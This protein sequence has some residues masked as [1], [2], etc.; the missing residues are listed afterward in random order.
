MPNTPNETRNG[1]PTSHGDFSSPVP[2]SSEIH[3]FSAV[4]PVFGDVPSTGP[5]TNAW[6]DSIVPAVTQPPADLGGRYRDFRPHRTGG[7]GRV[8]L[9]RDAVI[10]RD[11][12]LKELRPERAGVAALRARFLDE[13]RVTGQLEHPGIVPLYDLI[14]DPGRDG[15]PCY[16]MRFLAGRTFA[17]ATR[18]YH[19]TRAQGRATRL[20]WTALLDAFIAVCRAVAYAHARNVLHRD[21]KGENIVLGDFGEV[22]VVDWGLAKVLTGPEVAATPTPVVAP[23][24]EERGVT[25][26][27]AVF[28]T[29]AF[30]SPQLADG[31]SASIASDI[32][33]LGVI[34][35]ML[36]VGRLPYEGQTSADILRQIRASDPVPP[37]TLEPSVPLALDAICRKA[38]A[39]EPADRYRSADDLAADVRRWLADEPVEA[40]PDPWTVRLA[41]FARRNRT[42]VIATGAVLCS[43]VVAL[44]V[45]TGLIW[46]EQQRADQLRRRAEANF[47]VARGLALNMLDLA[48]TLPAA[49]QAEVVREGMT[50]MGLRTLEGFRSQRPDDHDLL[51]KLAKLYRYSANVHRNRNDLAVT[52][53]SY[54]EA[55]AILDV[56]AA[57]APTVEA[58]RDQLAET[59]RDH[60]QSLARLGRLTDASKELT[61]SVA[62]ASDLRAKNPTKTDYRRTLAISRLDLADVQLLLG[63]FRDTETSC[64]E[65]ETLLQGLSEPQPFDGLLQ[66][67]AIALRAEALREQAKNAEA[68]A[69]QSDAIT[70]LRTLHELAPDDINITHVLG[71]VLVERVQHLSATPEGRDRARANLDEAIRSWTDLIERTP[72]YPLYH[73][74]R[75]L[76]FV[77]RGRLRADTGESDA[78]RTD[79]RT[80]VEAFEKLVSQFP[81]VPGYMGHLGRTYAALGRL[82]PPAEAD[83]LFQRA[84]RLL[85]SACALAPDHA[86]DRRSLAELR[87]RGPPDPR[88]GPGGG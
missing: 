11:V 20:D 43:A 27:G 50:D 49:R 26:A 31:E 19:R 36:L 5:A 75:A 83:A 35:Y 10:G 53:V 24:D 40:M 77:A 17:E 74:W 66:A 78:A 14:S 60:S 22:F 57:K 45:T 3:P 23:V 87:R 41:R 72:S 63:R 42:A 56:L 15:G 7:L 21:L 25:Q 65:V 1:D 69:A 51:Q 68:L 37:R 86:L 58:Y 73:E 48:E 18:E 16:T 64:R 39:R 38:I 88:G 55:L 76:A 46:R 85:Q 54:R 30:L 80:A 2:T 32:Y 12:A 70:R 52:E 71:Q 79:L 81:N 84:E 9:V 61:R 44:T 47:D 29:P 28:G 67:M 82:V 34:L 62:V 6:V 8:W 13:A 59:L 4:E 33:A